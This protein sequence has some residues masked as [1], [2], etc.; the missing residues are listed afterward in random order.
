[1]LSIVECDSERVDH[2]LLLLGIS[3]GDLVEALVE[4]LVAK[5][6][7]QLLFGLCT[8]KLGLAVRAAELN[9]DAINLDGGF[10]VEGFPGERALH[11]FVLTA[12]HQ[13]LIGLGG[14]LL[15]VG[16]ERRWAL[17]AAEIDLALLVRQ[18]VILAGRLARDRAL[19]SRSIRSLGNA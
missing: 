11:L 13:L 15:H 7:V 18:G 19:E 2:P 10:R 14:E 6:H 12:H 16:F 4:G 8:F 1:M 3:R 5:D 9:A 17:I